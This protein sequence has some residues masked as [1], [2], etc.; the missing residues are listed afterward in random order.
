MS[1]SRTPRRRTPGRPSALHTKLRVAPERLRW[2][3]TDAMLGITSMEE[4]EPLTDIVGQPRAMGALRV[5][6][7]M[8]HQGYNVFATGHP[9]TGKTTAITRMLKEYES[10]PAEL[11]DMCY[12]Y[13]FRAS[14]A[15]MVLILPAGR[16]S[17]FKKDME[18]AVAELQKSIP[19]VFESRRYLEQRKSTLEH[20][21]E[22]QR[23]VL[24]DFEKRVKERGFEVVQVQGGTATRPEMEAMTSIQGASVP[25]GVRRALITIMA[26]T[27]ARS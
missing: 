20:F 10:R 16:G 27:T 8:T 1:P 4:V 12:V 6:L 19:A 14:D 18:S 25:S 13:N 21:Q 26:S 17:E 24:K 7:E 5:G 9:G 2:Q 15:P 3:C 23:S 22:R 11:N